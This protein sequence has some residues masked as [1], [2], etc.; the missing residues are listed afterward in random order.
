[1]PAVAPGEVALANHDFR[2]FVKGEIDS[3]FCIETLARA[4]MAL[5]AALGG[6]S[7]LVLGWKR[8]CGFDDNFLLSTRGALEDVV[9]HWRPR[10]RLEALRIAGAAA[11]A[12]GLWRGGHP[13]LGPILGKTRCSAC[14]RSR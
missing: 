12:S 14:A 6:A 10:L 11:S 7:D 8:G 1:M 9:A 4:S 13:N 3:V 2:I 5:G